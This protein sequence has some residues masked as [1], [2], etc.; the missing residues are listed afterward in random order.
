MPNGH[1]IM[2]YNLIYHLFSFIYYHSNLIWFYATNSIIFVPMRCP[3]L[4]NYF[5]SCQVNVDIVYATFELSITSI[6]PVYQNLSQG[7]FLKKKKMISGYNNYSSWLI[8]A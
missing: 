2:N 6:M 3:F 8:I 4:Q 5:L 7:Q 1:V